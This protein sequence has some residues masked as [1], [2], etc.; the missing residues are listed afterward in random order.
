MAR[1]DGMAAI[2]TGAATGIGYGIAKRLASEG[3]NI[4]IVDVDGSMGEQSA[5][6]LSARGVESKLVVGDVAELATAEEAA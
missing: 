2:V 4:V 1:F 6:E 3:A 5:S